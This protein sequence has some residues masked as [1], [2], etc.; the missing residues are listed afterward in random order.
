M[1]ALKNRATSVG[2][3]NIHRGSNGHNL[4]SNNNSTLLGNSIVVMVGDLNRRTLTIKRTES[5]Q[6][7]YG[8]RD[9]NNRDASPYHN[10]ND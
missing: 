4:R 5:L 8:I 9:S 6:Y 10:P 3:N 7:N 1:E 2:D